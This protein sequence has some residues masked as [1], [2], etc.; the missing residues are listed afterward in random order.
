M[1]SHC[2]YDGPSLI[3]GKP[4]VL[5]AGG[6]DKASVNSKTGPM[7]QTY[8]LRKDKTVWDA[9][10]D[11]SDVSIC[12]TCIHRPKDPDGKAR[13][14]YVDLRFVSPVWFAK[15]LPGQLAVLHGRDVRFGAYGD[16]AAVPMDVWFKMSLAARSWCGYT[17]FWKDVDDTEIGRRILMASVHS[18]EQAHEAWALGWRTYRDVRPTGTPVI[19]DREIVCPHYSH[20]TQCIKCKLCDGVSRH[21]G[22]PPGRRSIVAPVHGSRK[23]HNQRFGEQ[24]VLIGGSR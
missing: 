14:C 16:P 5:L 4:I 2:F 18:V 1:V 13:S 12:G 11:G 22:N 17:Q 9:I 20:Q 15:R 24:L 7:I 19:E 3:D 6:V 10:R 23:K 21:D 8:V